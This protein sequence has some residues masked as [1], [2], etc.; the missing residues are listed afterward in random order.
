MQSKLLYARLFPSYTRSFNN[1]VLLKKEGQEVKTWINKLAE[2]K[3]HPFTSKNEIMSLIKTKL[4]E[5]ETA[6]IPMPKSKP[7]RGHNGIPEFMSYDAITDSDTTT[8]PVTKPDTKPTTKPRPFGPGPMENPGPS[9]SDTTTKPVTKPDTKPVTK[10]RPF[11]PGPM[12][13]PGPS[14]INKKRK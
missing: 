2:E 5:V 1:A 14:A 7:N 11:G 6:S 8:K 9:A 10:P 3:Y 12:E 4:N 13:N